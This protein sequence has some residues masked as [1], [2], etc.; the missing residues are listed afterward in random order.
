[1]TYSPF[2]H[3]VTKQRF[4]ENFPVQSQPT[5]ISPIDTKRNRFYQAKYNTTHVSETFPLRQMPRISRHGCVVSA[6]DHG[7]HNDIKHVHDRPRARHHLARHRIFIEEL[8]A[9]ITSKFTDIIR[10]RN[11]TKRTVLFD[12]LLNI[13]RWKPVIEKL[14]LTTLQTANNT[15]L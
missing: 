2:T 12:L 5:S 14:T 4:V 11:T 7:G 10:K 8:L 6:P 9:R 15:N 1:M 3:T 13:E